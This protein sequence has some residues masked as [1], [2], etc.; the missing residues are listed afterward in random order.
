MP[1]RLETSSGSRKRKC[2]EQPQKG[3]Y[4]ASKRN[5]A[6]SSAVLD[7]LRPATQSD[8]KASLQAQQHAA[9]QTEN[10]KPSGK[11]GHENLGNSVADRP[12]SAA[13]GNSVTLKVC[14]SITKPSIPPNSYLPL[15]REGAALAPGDA[16][17]TAAVQK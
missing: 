11:S 4:R 14:S 5:K 16:A 8:P 3:E 12:R 1:L 13:R 6:R 10:Q 15:T 17:K 9:K 7:I 2:D